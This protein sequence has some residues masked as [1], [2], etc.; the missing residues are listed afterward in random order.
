MK[1]MSEK[2][3]NVKFVALV[4]IGLSAGFFFH[5]IAACFLSFFLS[6]LYLVVK[7]EE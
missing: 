1:T 4:G 7:S 5:S 3:S 2:K 6:L